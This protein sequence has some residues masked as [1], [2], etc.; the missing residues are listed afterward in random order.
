MITNSLFQP[1]D[2]FAGSTLL[3]LFRSRNRNFVSMR[4]QTLDMLTW[5]AYLCVH[6]LSVLE[7]LSADFF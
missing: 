4:I 1:G 6:V 2:F 3:L 7:C 5:L